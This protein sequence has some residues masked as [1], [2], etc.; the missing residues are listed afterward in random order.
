MILKSRFVRAMEIDFYYFYEKN[1]LFLLYNFFLSGLLEF[2]LFLLKLLNNKHK[3]FYFRNQYYYF[4]Y[5]R[6]LLA[7]LTLNCM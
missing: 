5:L 1:K 2:S 6:V 4:S 7:I 3:N